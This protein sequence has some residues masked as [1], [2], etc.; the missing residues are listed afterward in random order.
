VTTREGK[1]VEGEEMIGDRNTTRREG[2]VRDGKRKHG[3]ASGI[4]ARLVRDD[5]KL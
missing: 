5:P 4:S 3:I 1:G 2:I